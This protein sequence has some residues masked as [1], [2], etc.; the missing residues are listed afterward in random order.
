MASSPGGGSEYVADHEHS[1]YERGRAEYAGLADV[2]IVGDALNQA[3]SRARAAQEAGEYGHQRAAVLSADQ[4][5]R[6]K[7][8]A[9]GNTH[10]VSYAHQE[11]ARFVQENFD[12]AAVHDVGRVYHDHGQKFLEF[13]ERI[14]R[15]AAV[16]QETW[17]GEAGD[18]MR[19]QV[20][21][22]ADHMS[23]SGNAAQLTG[24]QLG[25][26]AEAGERARNSMPE[27]IEFD[28][29]EELR[30]YFADPNPLTAISRANEI[31]QKQQRSQAA[32]QEA[33]RV[34][35]AMETSFGEAAARTPAFVPAPRGPEE[36]GRTT[37]EQPGTLRTTDSPVQTRSAW[38][39]A[40]NSDSRST[41]SQPQHGTTPVW[42][43]QV[44]QQPDVRWN[45]QRNCWER[46]NPTSG[47]WVP[48]PP[49]EQR[50]GASG[51]RLSGTGG[52][53]GRTGRVGGIGPGKAGG[54]SG[55][56][57]RAGSGG[58][59]VAGRAGTGGSGATAARG[60]AG[61]AGAVGRGPDGESEED[62]AHENKY[63]LDTNEVWDDLGLPKVAP[64]VF[65][66]E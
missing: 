52:R 3:L 61:A 35:S 49:G 5:L 43:Q 12:P 34:M 59:G 65:G 32:H 2:P 10:Y 13:A 22:L 31:V 42:Q 57:G 56:G 24:N 36:Q 54:Q 45:H 7:P 21:R 41:P 64:P 63:A 17:H 11:L 9:L 26:Q 51:G 47:R 40:D 1:A 55:S 8:A 16:T 18:A 66:D 60:G 20:T 62:L 14:R 6:E 37:A 50:S 29:K 33:A 27:V 38:A 46:R 58:A 30:N 15:A 4:E 28:L 19:A 23:H 44:P 25:M 48:L 53:S 39:D